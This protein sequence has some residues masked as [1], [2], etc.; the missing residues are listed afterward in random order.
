M[1]VVEH[2]FIKT[3]ELDDLEIQKF[4]SDGDKKCY[5]SSCQKNLGN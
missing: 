3:V 1:K 5:E 4:R 2:R